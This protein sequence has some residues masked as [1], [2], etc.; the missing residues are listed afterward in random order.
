MWRDAT[1]TTDVTVASPLKITL[2]TTPSSNTSGPNMDV[3][4][5]FGETRVMYTG[6]F[7]AQ[8]F[9]SLLLRNA[10]ASFRYVDVVQ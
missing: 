1:N 3:T 9:P 10:I 7:D 8:F 6:F 5:I 2:E 4:C